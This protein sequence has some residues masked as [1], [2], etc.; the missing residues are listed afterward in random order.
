M[1][2]GIDP[3]P[4][5]A[6]GDELAAAWRRIREVKAELAIRRP[7]EVLKVTTRPRGGAVEVIA[8]LCRNADSRMPFSPFSTPG[9][10]R[11]LA[12]LG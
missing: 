2:Q 9:T 4:S 6:M 5:S 3:G 8:A 7:V 10:P 1:D 11:V 12:S